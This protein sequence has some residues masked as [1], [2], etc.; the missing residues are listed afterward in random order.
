MRKFGLLRTA[1]MIGYGKDGLPLSWQ[2]DFP[3]N[4]SCCR[5]GGVA[6]IAL[7]LKENADSPQYVC[8][9]RH[10]NGKGDYWLHDRGAFAIYL[11]R[12]CLEPTTLYNQA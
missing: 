10:N 8:N 9:L 7:T 12:D 2:K 6:R 3:E 11:C 5:C 1:L 4:T